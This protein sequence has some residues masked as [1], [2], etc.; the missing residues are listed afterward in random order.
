MII[1]PTC[2]GLGGGVGI[3]RVLGGWLVGMCCG[4]R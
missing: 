4:G 2:G 1:M 3:S